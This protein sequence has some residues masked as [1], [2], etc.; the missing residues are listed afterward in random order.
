MKKIYTLCTKV[1]PLKKKLLIFFK[2]INI[3]SKII[4]FLHAFPWPVPTNFLKDQI[5]IDKLILFSNFQK[6]LSY[7][8][9]GWK[10][11]Y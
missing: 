10:K 11:K 8:Y 7:K 6:T 4:C 3:Q 5:K 1:N 9:L 2:K